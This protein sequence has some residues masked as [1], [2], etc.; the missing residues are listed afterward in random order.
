MIIEARCFGYGVFLVMVAYLVGMI[1][2]VIIYNLCQSCLDSL[3]D[4]DSSNGL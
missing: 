2:S 4:K 1:V 3:E